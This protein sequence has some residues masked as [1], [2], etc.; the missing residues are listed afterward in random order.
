MEELKTYVGVAVVSLLVVCERYWG[1][2]LDSGLVLAEQTLAI[3]G[4]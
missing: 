1:V 4:L 3:W 2:G